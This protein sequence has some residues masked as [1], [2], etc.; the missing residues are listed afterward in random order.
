MIEETKWS[1]KPMWRCP[2]CKTTSLDGPGYIQCRQEKRISLKEI[3][4]A[5]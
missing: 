4:D 1:G 2:F 3:D 5:S